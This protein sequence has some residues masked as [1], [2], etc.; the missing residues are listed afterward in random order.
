MHFVIRAVLIAGAT[1]ALNGCVTNSYCLSDQDYQKAE[2]VPGIAPV[3]G[4]NVPH[5][6]SALTI[7]AAPEKTVPFGQTVKNK[8]GDD[9]VAC[10][11]Q[12]PR[13]PEAIAKSAEPAPGETVKP[14]DEAG[15]SSSMWWWV[16]GGAVVVAAVL[17]IV[18]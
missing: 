16:A 7:P 8:D 2:S 5:S 4:L 3:E 1:A 13:L 10:L 9:E 17:L 11:D 14:P 15:S 18:L 6:Q 12:P